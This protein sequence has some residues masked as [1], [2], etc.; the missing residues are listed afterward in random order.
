MVNGHRSCLPGVL[1]PEQPNIDRCSNKNI[2]PNP[3]EPMAIT[4]LSPESMRRLTWPDATI[5]P[6][7]TYQAQKK[8]FMSYAH[9]VF[10]MASLLAVG[11]CDCS[12]SHDIEVVPT[13]SHDAAAHN[14]T[15]DSPGESSN[16]EPLSTLSPLLVESTIVDGTVLSGGEGLVLVLDLRSATQPENAPR[17]EMVWFLN[18]TET[19]SACATNARVTAAGQRVRAEALVFTEHQLQLDSRQNTADG[20]FEATGDL[21][22]QKAGQFDVNIT[23]EVEDRVRIHRT[24]SGVCSADLFV[25]QSELRTANWDS[26]IWRVRHKSTRYLMI[27]IP[28]PTSTPTNPVGEW[29]SVTLNGPG[30]RLDWTL[31]ANRWAVASADGGGEAP[32]LGQG[33][34]T[35]GPKGQLE[36]VSDSATDV[37]RTGYMNPKHGGAIVYA[38]PSGGNFSSASYWWKRG[39]DAGESATPGTWHIVGRRPAKAPETGLVSGTLQLASDGGLRGELVSLDTRD[40][41]PFIGQLNS[42]IPSSG[43]VQFSFSPAF[44]DAR[45][46]ESGTESSSAAPHNH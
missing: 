10:F 7:G 27:G 16:P 42:G 24:I 15:S 30:Q 34:Y 35:V 29:R 19:G 12:H 44:N 41:I 37:D 3:P 28:E 5:V 23:R 20:G 36:L 2:T 22:W 39:A 40:V 25:A 33:D 8:N 13:P 21:F 6:S 38:S 26:T 9:L 45:V 31:T 32:N 1:F 43:K 46:I 17:D 18:R 11:G 14:H 4:R